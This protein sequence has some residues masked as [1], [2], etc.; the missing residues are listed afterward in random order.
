MIVAKWVDNKIA[1]LCS[2]YAGIK[3]IN[4]NNSMLGQNE[5]VTGSH[6]MYINRCDVQQEHGWCWFDL[7]ADC[8]ESK[9]VSKLKDGI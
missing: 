3:P 9:S 5:K 4:V 8:I 7:Y 2:N 6:S 1:Q